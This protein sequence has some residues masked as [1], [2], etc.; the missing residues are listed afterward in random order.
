MS[1]TSTAKPVELKIGTPI[2]YD[3]SHSTVL[4]WLYSVKAYLLINKDAYSDDDKKVAYAL[5]YMKKGVAL[6]WAASYY[7][8]CLKGSTPSVT[9]V[10]ILSK[11]LLRSVLNS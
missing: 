5:S 3:G 1:H 4:S 10:H 7:K 11:L 6:D 2:D 9:N 8:Q